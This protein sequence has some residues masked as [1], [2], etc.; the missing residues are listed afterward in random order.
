M[1]F[2]HRLLFAALSLSLA[3]PSPTFAAPQAA[4]N[5]APSSAQPPSAVPEPKLVT[6]LY[7]IS[8]ITHSV[9]QFPY[10]GELPAT[11]GSR[12]I[13]T[14]DRSDMFMGGAAGGA[15]GGTGGGGGGM[16]GGGGGGFF[17][18]PATPVQF[19]SGGG[20]GGGLGGGPMES[21]PAQ[22]E[23][24]AETIASNGDSF[25]QLLSDFVEP[26]SWEDNGGRG[27][28]R[29]IGRTLL[30]S[31]TEEVHTKIAAFLRE[32]TANIPGHRPYTLE[33]WWLPLASADRLALNQSMIQFSET[34]Q[35]L[36][37]LQQLSDKTRGFHGKLQCADR[38]A[39]NFSS[40]YRRPVVV[41]KVPVVGSGV[42]GDHPIVRHLLIGLMLEVVVDPVAEFQIDP[43][44]QDQVAAVR[45]RSS[46]TH[47]DAPDVAVE[48]TLGIDRFKLGA[49]VV[50]GVTWLRFGQPAIVGSLS[51]VAGPQVEGAD[52]NEIV[53]V[54]M[55]TSAPIEQAK[56]GR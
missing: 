4:D 40:G 48:N 2:T 46:L 19:G 44:I 37:H 42:S 34:E 6:K 3:G 36:A 17:S 15:I 30:V 47:D 45:F 8:T 28:L 51:S 27:T 7:D 38:I 24:V 55:L 12:A 52:Q 53:M 14:G 16:G 50:E 10:T 35:Q 49:H 11:S 33:V 18:V 43:A 31:Q 41:G 21:Q 56:A 26:D 32:L 1:L 23:S 22:H 54:M 5:S 25:G 13:S 9:P 20:S 29:E 39:A